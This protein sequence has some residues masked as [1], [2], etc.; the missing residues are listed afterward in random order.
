MPSFLRSFAVNEP[1]HG[2]A[3]IVRGRRGQ[4]VFWFL[5][6]GVSC[7][8][9]MLVNVKV[10]QQYSNEKVVTQVLTGKPSHIPSVLLCPPMVINWSAA[11]AVHRSDHRSTF[12]EHQSIVKMLTTIDTISPLNI[13]EV[14]ESPQMEWKPY[15]LSNIDIDRVI[16]EAHRDQFTEMIDTIG[17][18][19]VILPLTTVITKSLRVSGYCYKIHVPESKISL[20]GYKF[21]NFIISFSTKFGKLYPWVPI[22]LDHGPDYVDPPVGIQ[23]P[24]NTNTLLIIT[25]TS[26]TQLNLKRRSFQDH[27]KQGNQQESCFIRCI[28]THECMD[29]CQ[30]YEPGMNQTLAQVCNEARGNARH[31]LQKIANTSCRARCK[32]PCTVTSYEITI[33]QMVVHRSFRLRV[34]FEHPLFSHKAVEELAVTPMMLFGYVA[35]NLGSFLGFSCFSFIISTLSAGIQWR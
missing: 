1:L 31:C 19:D 25:E 24:T 5:A 30:L 28:N 33:T 2:L 8:A 27:G 13:V 35:S 20:M 32:N 3:Q 29:G 17:I 15:N 6:F 16:E 22:V 12:E 4:K 26:K 21:I 10:M 11:A 9:F 7:A 18:Q 34:R 23:L 14:G